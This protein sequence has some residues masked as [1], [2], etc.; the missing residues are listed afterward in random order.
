[1]NYRL[2]T[3]AAR[4]LDE[5]AEWFRANALDHRVALRFLLEVRAAFKAIAEAPLAFPEVHGNI[6]RCP[7]H[8]GNSVA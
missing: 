8:V 2:R 1:V 3:A 4:D 7:V 5:A 6:R